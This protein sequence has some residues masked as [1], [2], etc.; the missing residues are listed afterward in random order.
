MQE[1]CEK[2]R[3]R[4]TLLQKHNNVAFTHSLDR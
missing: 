2:W 4:A 3:N 1:H